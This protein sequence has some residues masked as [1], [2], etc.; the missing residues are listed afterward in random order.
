M[1]TKA[2]KGEF[3]ECGRPQR[4]AFI[5]SNVK[6]WFSSS[7]SQAQKIWV[8]FMLGSHILC[9][10]FRFGLMRRMRVRRL[11]VVIFSQ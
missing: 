4:V 8:P 7:C 6:K 11:D 1:R 2:D 10:E 3:S 5:K 9:S